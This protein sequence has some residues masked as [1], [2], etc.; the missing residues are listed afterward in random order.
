MIRRQIP[1]SSN[2]LV[3]SSC[4]SSP[5]L[6]YQQFWCASTPTSSAPPA[7]RGIIKNK[8]D[9]E[10]F[11][12]MMQQRNPSQKVPTKMNVI[13]LSQRFNQG[14]GL[15]K[16]E[17]DGQFKAH[18]IDFDISRGGK[19]LRIKWKLTQQQKPQNT[20]LLEE[21]EKEI[22]ETIENE[23]DSS[24]SSTT[25][26]RFLTTQITAELMRVCAPSTDVLSLPD[27]VVVSGKRGVLF[28][29]MHLV[30]NYAVRVTYSDGHTAGI[31][32]YQYLYDLSGPEKWLRS[33]HY[34]T[35]LYKM[36]R[37]RNPP[38]KKK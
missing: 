14:G 9:I 5:I 25:T 15:A 38:Q 19:L 32:G 7:K 3:S 11:Q 4:F 36:G 24:S 21:K 12:K 18:P 8:N 13:P 2:S 28:T 20:N 6:S 29:D 37:S 26:T 34:L 27:N 17:V 30:G 1:F 33:R 16:P 31:Y 23:N 10:E 22:K 35:T